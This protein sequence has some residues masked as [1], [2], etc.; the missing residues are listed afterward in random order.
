MEDAQEHYFQSVIYRSVVVANVQLL[1]YTFL[2]ALF[3]DILQDWCF[4]SNTSIAW[5]Q[6]AKMGTVEMAATFYI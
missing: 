1:W 6:R 3:V 5:L 2:V 4:A